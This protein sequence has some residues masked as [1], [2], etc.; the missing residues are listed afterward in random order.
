MACGISPVT[1]RRINTFI[2][3]DIFIKTEIR[4]K[5]GSGAR[6]RSD[7]EGPG[8]VRGEFSMGIHCAFRV[9]LIVGA[10]VMI[11]QSTPA[12]AG[13]LNF[14][15]SYT[16]SELGTGA[17]GD[18]TV[19]GE[20]LGLSDN[21]SNQAAADVMITGFPSFMTGLPAAPFDLF[22]GGAFLV[23]NSVS[24]SGGQITA[25]NISGIGGD[26]SF[27]F[28]TN[29]MTLNDLSA[30]ATVQSNAGGTYTPVSTGSSAVPE[31]VSLTILAVGLA[32]LAANRRRRATPLP[33]ANL[34]TA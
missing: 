23:A 13:L 14:D 1:V 34:L 4:G 30:N 10:A 6:V 11:A 15:F 3:A 18:G 12:R 9:A 17:S 28:E 33:T 19:T 5:C 20:I 22:G 8:I 24:V 31:P 21:T 32:G 25:I 26:D 7:S 2:G 27:T 16:G 29:S